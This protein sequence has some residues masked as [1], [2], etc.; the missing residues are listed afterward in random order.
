MM[1][2]LDTQL[3]NASRGDG[4]CWASQ[5]WHPGMR[6]TWRRRSGLSLL[7]VLIATFVLSVGVLGLMSLVPLGGHR[8]AQV[9]NFDAGAQLGRAALGQVVARGILEPDRWVWFNP[10]SGALERTWVHPDSAWVHPAYESLGRR[11]NVD[12][13]AETFCI[14][15]LFIAEAIEIQGAVP[16]GNW[17]GW[18]FPYSMDHTPT[19]DAPRMPRVSL[20]GLEDFD[21]TI[22]G[23]PA[24]QIPQVLPN[25]PV[26]P[27]F[28]DTVMTPLLAERTF[29]SS[30]DPVF[31]SPDD[32]TLAPQRM[33]TGG[34]AQVPQTE[35]G[36]SWMVMVSRSPQ[37][38]VAVNDMTLGVVDI[39]P[40]SR[41]NYRVSII[42]YEG[43]PLDEGVEQVGNASFADVA[44]QL[45]SERTCFIQFPGGVGIGG[46]DVTI[47]GGPANDMTGQ[48]AEDY[49]D[50]APNQWIMVCSWTPRG[51]AGPPNPGGAAAGPTFFSGS[52]DRTYLPVYR[53]YRVVATDSG[54]RVDPN[55][56][57][58]IRTITLDGADWTD[59]NPNGNPW[60]AV[61]PPYDQP[62]A[63]LVDGVVAVYE[64]TINR[65][66]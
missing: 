31:N 24:A 11:R 36:Y 43:R 35:G 18:T 14:D 9:N 6:A 22:T 66:P 65:R 39:P 8:I 29:T 3:E 5:Q 48:Q 21:G 10:G 49:L 38:V 19:F 55:T 27:S 7:E 16:P 13:W 62:Y 30:F 60:P 56:G 44:A 34:D 33:Y 51:T 53:W 50:V 15:P 4:H 57:N 64:K 61:Q 58:W 1:Y 12:D 47:S 32:A 46:G 45:P 28:I 41:T 25:P 40:S 52:Q 54:P 20:K 26:G 63:V 23:Q 42:V 37:E 17:P 59:P 2:L